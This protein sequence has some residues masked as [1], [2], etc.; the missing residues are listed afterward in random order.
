M[1][2]KEINNDNQNTENKINFDELFDNEN[3][4]TWGFL[5]DPQISDADEGC[6]QS[7]YHSK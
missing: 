7:G 4:D 3:I 2:E 1:N 6:T 5:Q